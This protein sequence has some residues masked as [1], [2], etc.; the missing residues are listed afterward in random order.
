MFN[1]LFTNRVCRVFTQKPL[2]SPLCIYIIILYSVFAAS[3]VVLSSNLCPAPTSGSFEDLFCFS[4]QLWM[5][6]WAIISKTP[7]G[8]LILSEKGSEVHK[9]HGMNKSKKHV[10]NSPWPSGV[11]QSFCSVCLFL[12][13]EKTRLLRLCFSFAVWSAS[14]QGDSGPPWRSFF[15]AIRVLSSMFWPAA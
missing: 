3:T 10:L 13:L 8:R 12:N 1:M 6:Q 11:L 9:E 4:S 2:L 5:I 15:S 7:R 14:I